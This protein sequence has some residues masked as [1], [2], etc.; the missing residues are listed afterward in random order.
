MAVRISAVLIVR[1]EESRLPKCL[2][3]LR[4]VADEIVIVDT[5]SRD[6]TVAAARRYTDNVTSFAWCDDFAAARNFALAHASGDWV[7]SMDADEVVIEPESARALLV[8]FANAQEPNT[9]GTIELHSPTGPELDAAVVVDR[10]PRFFQRGAW[11][12]EGAI[13]EQLVPVSTAGRVAATGLRVSHSGY[14]QAVDD[15][16]HK[17]KRNIPLLLKALAE[18]A[19][20]EY[21]L[22][23]FGKAHYSL[24][25]YTDATAAFERALQSIRFAQDAPPTGRCGPVARAVLTDL[26]T[27]L[28]YA[29]VNTGAA[30]KACAHLERHRA[31]AHPGTERAD[32]WHVL[33]Y[34]Y[35][36]LGDIARSKEGYER[37]LLFGP[38]GEDVLGTGSFSSEYHLG[39]LAEA[40]GDLE[41][42]AAHYAASL[43]W[44][45]D[46]RPTLARVVD[47]IVEYNRVPAPPIVQEIDFAVFRA[48]CD[49]KLRAFAAAGNNDAVRKVREAVG[50]VSAV[51]NVKND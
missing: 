35:L 27:T 15:P 46:Y 6:G 36:V 29:Y 23:Q 28:A 22:H 10:L 37:S 31:L 17:A 38:D 1:D 7:L 4:L 44:K 9:L 30:E 51:F 20:D 33:G 32:F 19:D 14:A 49:E 24:K 11:C 26:V 41:H 21:L 13:H 48:V 43:R 3:A 50:P 34:V 42:A 47:W 2:D 16:R 12:F 45:H 18:H 5:G 39:L 25:Q 40:E 8:E